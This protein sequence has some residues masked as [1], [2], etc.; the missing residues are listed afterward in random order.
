LTPED[1]ELALT[2]HSFWI[3]YNILLPLETVKYYVRFQLV[4]LQEIRRHSVQRHIRQ[5]IHL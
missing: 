3:S 1:S 2:F 4:T 5:C